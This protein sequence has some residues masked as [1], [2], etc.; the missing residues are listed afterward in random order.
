MADHD[1]ELATSKTE[2]FKVGE[3]KTLEE[4]KN[5]DQN[6][7]SLNRWKASLGLN[8]GEPIGDP[9][10]LRKCIIE[11]LTIEAPGRSDITLDLTGPNALE[12]LKDKPFTIKEGAKFYTKVVFQ[13]HR[14]VLS[15]LKYVHVVKRKGITVT[16]DEEMLGSYAPNTTDKRNYEKRFHEEEAPSGMLARGHYN[17]RSRF[18]DDDKQVHLEFQWAFDIAKD[19]AK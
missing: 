5:L 15:G 7:E 1:D 12:S 4:Y 14:E 6:D 19:W 9:N 3:K 11:S 2:G 13:V 17:V 10:D 16:K 18:V 8:T